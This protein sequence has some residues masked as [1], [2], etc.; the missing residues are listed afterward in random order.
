MTSKRS[1]QKSQTQNLTLREGTILVK[2]A[3]EAITRYLEKK[4]T[5]KP[6]SSNG[7]LVRK[8]G[9]FV[10]LNTFKTHALRGCIGFPYPDQPLIE[11]TVKAAIY[12]ATEDPRFE[13]VTIEEFGQSI[14]IELTALTAPKILRAANRKALP[15]LIEI[16]RHGLIIEGMRCSGLLLPQVAVEWEWD[17]TDFLTNCCLKAGLPADSWLLNEVT[18]KVFEGEIFEETEPAGEVKKRSFGA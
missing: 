12:A 2:L 4:I 8:S 5:I 17:G 14:A 15:E 11:A 3:R 16:G 1:E 6:P 10:T 18:V 9:V 7:N 13:P